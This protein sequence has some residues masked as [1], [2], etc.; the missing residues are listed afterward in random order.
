MDSFGDVMRIVDM[1]DGFEDLD[2]WIHVETEFDAEM[3]F[4][5]YIVVNIC[6]EMWVLWYICDKLWFKC[7]KI[8]KR[9]QKNVAQQSWTNFS[10]EPSFADRQTLSTAT[11]LLFADSLPRGLSAKNLRQLVCRRSA[12]TSPIALDLAVGEGLTTPSSFADWDGVV[13]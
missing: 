6:D 1:Y 4:I 13:G 12:K 10:V 3:W 7:N 2:V 11:A 8:G 9:K 5:C